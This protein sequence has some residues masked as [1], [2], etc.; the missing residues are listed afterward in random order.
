MK[1]LTMFSAVLLSCSAMAADVESRHGGHSGGTLGP[2]G[3][4]Q[5]VALKISKVEQTKISDKLIITLDLGDHKYASAKPEQWTNPTPTVES[6]IK[7]RPV[8]LLTVGNMPVLTAQSD[9]KGKVTGDFQ[10][11]LFKKG[12]G[13]K[14]TVSKRK[15]TELL[16]QLMGFN[17]ENPAK[18]KVVLQDNHPPAPVSAESQEAGSRHGSPLAE[19]EF[20][21]EVKENTKQLIGRH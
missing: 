15:L 6:G 11:Q 5:Q 1:F 4:K 20:E 17:D 12:A 21:I 2:N 13:I 16:S 10:A 9:L 7:Y 14:L 19:I 8:L 18:V 3:V